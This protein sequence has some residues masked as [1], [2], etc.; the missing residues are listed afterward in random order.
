MRYL[1]KLHQGVFK[2]KMSISALQY[3]FCFDELPFKNGMPLWRT[4]NCK[5]CQNFRVCAGAV[6]YSCMV[7]KVYLANVK[8]KILGHRIKHQ[9]GYMKIES[10][11]VFNLF[12]F[13]SILN[14]L[15]SSQSDTHEF[16]S[17][18][19]YETMTMMAPTEHYYKN[20]RCSSEFDSAE[21]LSLLSPSDGL[22]RFCIL[23]S[24][25]VLNIYENVVMG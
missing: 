13:L 8:V 17:W 18:I 5:N 22:Q 7:F 19:W 15:D 14:E 24:K 11:T 1:L 3:Q 12:L 23:V 21:W 25:S 20:T 16:K 2:E 10:Q 4:Q 6:V 9:V